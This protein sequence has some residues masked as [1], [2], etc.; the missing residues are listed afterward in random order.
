MYCQL[1]LSYGQV[2]VPPVLLSVRGIPSHI[3]HPGKDKFQRFQ[4]RDNRVDNLRHPGPMPVTI[5]QNDHR[6]RPCFIQD[7]CNA[8]T[9]GL[10]PVRRNTAPDHQPK[11]MFIEQR[12]ALRGEKTVRWADVT[13]DFGWNA[14][15]VGNQVASGIQSLDEPGGAFE[16]KGEVSVAM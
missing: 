6:A 2:K 13:N 15:N 7:L 16:Y 9:D 8:P 12:Q 4:A 10:H 3:F 11:L 5:M 14:T 1:P